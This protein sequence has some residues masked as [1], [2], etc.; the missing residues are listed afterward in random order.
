MIGTNETFDTE[1]PNIIAIPSLQGQTLQVRYDGD[2]TE[3][4]LHLYG[5]RATTPCI[6]TF[7]MLGKQVRY[8]VG[9]IATLKHEHEHWLTLFMG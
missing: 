7:N 9:A 6:D 8:D 2:L 1:M 4:Y 5:A 3:L